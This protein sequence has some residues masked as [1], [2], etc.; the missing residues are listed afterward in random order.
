MG[1]TKAAREGRF[2]D[3]TAGSERLA[4]L[5]ELFVGFGGSIRVMAGIAEHLGLA[6]EASL[7][8]PIQGLARDQRDRVVEVIN[9]LGLHR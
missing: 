9:A 7:P 4:P 8:L 2:S 6:P 5:W 1:I 3:A